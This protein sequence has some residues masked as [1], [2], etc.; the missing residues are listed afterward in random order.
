MPAPMMQ[1]IPSAVRLT[2]PRVLPRAW[3]SPSAMMS[4]RGFRVI[5][6][7]G[8]GLGVKAWSV[9]GTSLVAVGCCLR[10]RRDLVLRLARI[11]MKTPYNITGVQT[12][13]GAGYS[14]ICAEVI[15][16]ARLPQY[17]SRAW[18][19]PAAASVS[20]RRAPR[21]FWE[22][23]RREGGG[24][25]KPQSVALV[26]RELPGL[27]PDLAGAAEEPGAAPPASITPCL[28]PDSTFNQSAAL[29]TEGS[30]SCGRTQTHRSRL[31]LPNRATAGVDVGRILALPWRPATA[32]A[33][34]LPHPQVAATETVR[35]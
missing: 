19:N 21:R 4:A 20:I 28:A 13:A 31:L 34:L 11:V 5:K 1:P 16:R 27:D 29:I 6:P 15:E 3:L 23:A 24:I 14:R 7:W 8:D 18:P 9:I 22:S 35:V 32:V 25:G 30:I 26:L 2:G 33:D 12:P 17:V 10:L